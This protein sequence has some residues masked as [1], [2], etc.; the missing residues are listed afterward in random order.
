MRKRYCLGDC[1]FNGYFTDQ[2]GS[3][4]S[5]I[6][7]FRGHPYQRGR[8]FGSVLAKYGIPLLK[9]LGKQFL[10]TGVAVGT[11]ML[12]RR[13]IKESLRSR[14]SESVNT[15]GHT[16]VDKLSKLISQSGSGRL[17]K[18]KPRKLKR[19]RPKVIKSRKTIK[20]KV[21]R[22]RPRDIFF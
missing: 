14:L 12:Q 3:G 2:A 19:R 13:P 21:K 17:Y 16:G 5:D 6:T 1:N 9:Y 20:R 7:V 4:L 8:G 10:S 11:D 22:R 18:R 15:I